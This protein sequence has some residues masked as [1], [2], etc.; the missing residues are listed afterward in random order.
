MKLRNIM[1]ASLLLLL[2]GLGIFFS[3]SYLLGAIVMSVFG[4]ITIFSWILWMISWL[5]P[6]VEIPQ[7]SWRRGIAKGTRRGK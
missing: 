6:E 1:L 4:F 3:V 2:A 7:L 5:Q